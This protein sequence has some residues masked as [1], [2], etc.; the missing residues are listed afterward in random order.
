[1]QT[2]SIRPC[3]LQ[4]C[5]EGCTSSLGVALLI[6]AT[7]SSRRFLASSSC[8]RSLICSSSVL[9]SLS[10]VSMF[11]CFACEQCH[12]EGKPMLAC[13][14]CKSGIEA[15]SVAAG[16][17]FEL[18]VTQQVCG[19]LCCLH[20]WVGLRLGGHPGSLLCR[21]PRCRVVPQED[22]SFALAQAGLSWQR[23][24]KAQWECPTVIQDRWWA[25]AEQHS[26]QKV[27]LHVVTEAA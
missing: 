23:D 25:L 4:T 14:Q 7:F 5:M 16:N 8:C 15:P 12:S 1:M 26:S 10:S 21:F 11:R 22:L 17:A 18:H 27:V 13:L 9:V 2:T 19:P 20:A 24:S 3:G 6:S